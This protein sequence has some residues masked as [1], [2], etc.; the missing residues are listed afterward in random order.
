MDAGGLVWSCTS[1]CLV[2]V[3]CGGLVKLQEMLRGVDAAR[4]FWVRSY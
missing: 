1:T 4:G 3:W 2:G